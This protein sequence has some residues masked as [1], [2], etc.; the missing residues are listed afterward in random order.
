MESIGDKSKIWVNESHDVGHGH[1]K[2]ISWVEQDLN[3]SKTQTNL[4]I[5]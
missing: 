2:L 4:V 3:P 5:Y 1:L